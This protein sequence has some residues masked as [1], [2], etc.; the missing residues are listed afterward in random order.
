MEGEKFVVGVGTDKVT[1]W[2]QQLEAYEHR[3]QPTDSEHECDR[4]EVKYRDSF[5]VGGEQPG[6]PTILRIEV[7]RP[8][9]DQ[10]VPH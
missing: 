6:L 3:K 1:L 8:I 10:F 2:R 7:I 4:D 5:M 9:A